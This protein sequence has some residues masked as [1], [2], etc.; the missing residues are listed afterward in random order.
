MLRVPKPGYRG[1]ATSARWTLQ[2]RLADSLV[3][4]GVCTTVDDL[5]VPR[6]IVLRV[7]CISWDCISWDVISVVREVARNLR[8]GGSS[9]GLEGV[10]E[11]FPVGLIKLLVCSS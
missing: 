11:F 8:A 7:R 2:D 1:E 5:V 10:T 6:G 3:C 4:T 9:F